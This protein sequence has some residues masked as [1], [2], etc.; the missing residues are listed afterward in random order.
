[1]SASGPALENALHAFRRQQ[2]VAIPIAYEEIALRAAAKRGG[3]MPYLTA[4]ALG[5]QNRV[6]EGLAEKCSDVEMLID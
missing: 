4:V 5:I 2:L 3:A 1:M 6:I